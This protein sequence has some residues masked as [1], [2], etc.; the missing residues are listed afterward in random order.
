MAGKKLPARKPKRDKAYAAKLRRLNPRLTREWAKRKP[1]RPSDYTTECCEAVIALGRKGLSRAQ[2]AAALDVARSTMQEWEKKHVEFAAA[3]ARARDVALAWWE[4]A[5]QLGL[6]MGKEFNATAFIFQ[7]CN[8]F[9]DDYRQRQE[10]T[11]ANGLPLVQPVINITI[12]HEQPSARR[13]E[14]ASSPQAG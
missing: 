6:T 13:A 7:M 9:G 10:M 8:R 12:G 4:D 3:M 5:G 11:G 1:G 14:P 2:I